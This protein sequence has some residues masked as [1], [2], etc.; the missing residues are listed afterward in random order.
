MLC[1][2]SILFPSILCRVLTNLIGGIIPD[3]WIL[4]KRQNLTERE[5]N[6]QQID[7]KVRT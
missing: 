1:V 6:Y 4:K 7:K 3:R 2:F 5:N